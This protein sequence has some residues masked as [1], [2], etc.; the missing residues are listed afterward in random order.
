MNF[1]LFKSQMRM[2]NHFPFDKIL[3]KNY[4]RKKKI[5]SLLVVID[6][7]SKI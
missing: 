7:F 1:F 6:I 2:S 5:F 3:L 4:E